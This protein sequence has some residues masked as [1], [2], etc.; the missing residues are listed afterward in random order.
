MV[1]AVGGTVF[2]VQAFGTGA[3]TAPAEP[4]PPEGT[5]MGI[6]PELT[7]DDATAAQMAVD[8]GDPEAQ[9]RLDP[10]AVAERFGTEALGWEIA[11]TPPD[12]VANDGSVDVVIAA[13][14]AI[15]PTPEA[16]VEDSCP[17][18]RMATIV[19][20]QPLEEG[21]HGIWSVEELRSDSIRI[22]LERGAP[23]PDGVTEVRTDLDDTLDAMAGFGDSDGPC[24]VAPLNTSGSSEVASP[25]ST[26]GS[27]CGEEGSYFWAMAFEDGE[28]MPTMEAFDPFGG[29]NPVAVALLP[30]V[31]P[32]TEP[33]LQPSIT[34]EP[35]SEPTSEPTDEPSPTG[36]PPGGGAVDDVLRVRC[37]DNDTMLDAHQV[38]AQADG[39]HVRVTTNQ[40]AGHATFVA[41]LDGRDAGHF[42]TFTKILYEPVNDFVYSYPPGG[43]LVACSDIERFD[44]AKGAIQPIL[45]LDPL[46]VWVD[47]RLGCPVQSQVQA[48]G[49]QA[50]SGGTSPY[51]ESPVLAVQL[52]VPGVAATDEVVI[53]EYGTPTSV[54]SLWVIV[55]RDGRVLAQFDVQGGSSGESWGVH[56][57]NTCK[58]SGVADAGNEPAVGSEITN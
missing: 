2:A 33:S 48:E 36:D 19:L 52:H 43:I 35:T 51:E 22:E 28:A 8:A 40:E 38:R 21:R 4:R 7:L 50:P 15:C 53:S 6:W 10:V 30:L 44:P 23:L 34:P 9:W 17:A 54:G 14:M 41:S 47:D 25:M 56:T 57:G 39:V 24:M 27:S 45:V 46:G 37:S 55:R 16:G 1:I 31:R 29:A 12:T 58:G 13:E 18:P 20:D 49:F 11:A 42:E 32:T 3:T 26:P 5:F